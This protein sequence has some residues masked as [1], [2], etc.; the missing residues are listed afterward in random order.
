MPKQR[1]LLRPRAGPV[2]RIKKNSGPCR[3]IVHFLKRSRSPPAAELWNWIN[4]RTLSTA[5]HRAVRLWLKSGPGR[6]GI[7]GGFLWW[8][9]PALE[10]IGPCAAEG[11]C[12]ESTE[13]RQYGKELPSEMV[14]QY[15][16]HP[17]PELLCDS[18]VGRFGSGYVTANRSFSTCTSST[19]TFAASDS[20]HRC[21]GD[22]R[23]CHELSNLGR[24]MGRG[25]SAC[26]HL[27]HGDR[28]E[29]FR[30]G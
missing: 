20:C 2:S 4:W 29:Q 10:L 9:W 18:A 15:S 5:F 1:R 7:R 24:T 28:K 13:I 19:R 3:S 6:S 16:G 27:T 22:G 26:W 23:V 30:D 14:D 25:G 17:G 8:Q 21:A 12:H 11:D